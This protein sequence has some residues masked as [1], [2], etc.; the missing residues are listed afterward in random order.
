MA[1]RTVRTPYAH[2]RRACPT[3]RL[4]SHLRCSRPRPKRSVRSGSRRSRRL[5]VGRLG[6]ARARPPRPMRRRVGLMA[7]GCQR[8]LQWGRAMRQRSRYSGPNPNP[9]PDPDPDPD[10]N[11]NAGTRGLTLT[12]TLTL[13][14][15]AGARGRTRLAAVR[16]GGARASRRAATARERA[17]QGEG[18]G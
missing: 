12:L 15:N 2:R 3:H 10:P 17:A 1:R 11:P 16:R 7:R 5:H 4:P 8:R 18:S 9:N 6:Q 14:P 13:N